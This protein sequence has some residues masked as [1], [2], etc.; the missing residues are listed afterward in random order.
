MTTDISKIDIRRFQRILWAPLTRTEIVPRTQ[1]TGSR[2]YTRHSSLNV[3]VYQEIL[4][5][6]SSIGRHDAIG[7]AFTTLDD[8]VVQ[9]LSYGMSELHEARDIVLSFPGVSSRDAL[10]AAM[11]QSA[12]ITQILSY[13]RGFDSIPGIQRLE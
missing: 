8:I 4:H 12:G 9:V 13:D 3:E 11:M 1:L 5:R 6:F 2:Q 10:H 7:E